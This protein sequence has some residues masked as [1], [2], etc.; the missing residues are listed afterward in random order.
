MLAT[1]TCKVEFKKGEERVSRVM[2][3]AYDSAEAPTRYQD[4]G[5]PPI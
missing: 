3:A 5:K 4:N 1:I 2:L